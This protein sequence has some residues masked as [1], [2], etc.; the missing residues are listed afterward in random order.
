[1]TKRNGGGWRQLAKAALRDE[2]RSRHRTPF[3]VVLIVHR[4]LV[5]S[6]AA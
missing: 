3:A 5:V 1:M 6:D 4:L 2:G